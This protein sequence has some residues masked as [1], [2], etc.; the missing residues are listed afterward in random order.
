MG[1]RDDAL[2]LMFLLGIIV[3]TALGIVVGWGI[4]ELI[5]GLTCTW[6]G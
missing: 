3:L 5:D 6:E 2:G 4:I 1:K